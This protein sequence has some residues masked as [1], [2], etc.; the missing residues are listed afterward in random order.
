MPRVG[1]LE[2][3]QDLPFECRMQ[4]AQRLGWGVLALIVLAA[5][6]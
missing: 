4:I 3:G 1:D 5:P 2:I 6:R